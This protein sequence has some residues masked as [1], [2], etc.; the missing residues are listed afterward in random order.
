MPDFDKKVSVI[1][2]V[3]NGEKSLKKCLDSVVNQTIDKNLIEVIAVDDGSSDGTAEILNGYEKEYPFFRCFFVE[4]G[5]PAQARNVGIEMAAGKYLA[6]LDSDDSISEDVLRAC[7]EFFDSRYDETDV[8]TY[9]LVPVENG[10]R[11][12]LHYRYDFLRKT[13]VYDLNDSVYRYS[14]LTNINV[15]VKN[16]GDE[17]ILFD[18][19]ND[20]VYEN[21]QYCTDNLLR[22]MT[23]GFVEGCE[24]LYER[25]A[26]SSAISSD[27]AA[28]FEVSFSKWE[29]TFASFDGSAPPYIQALFFD[30]LQL[31]LSEDTL[32][33][34]HFE[35]KPFDDA[36]DRIRQLLKKVSDGIILS[37]TGYPEMLGFY[38]LDM[39]YSGSLTFENGEKAALSYGDEILYETD[40]VRIVIDKF[41]FKG[42]ILEVCGHLSSPVFRYCSKPQLLIRRKDSAESVE[43]YESSFCYEGAK[44]KTNMAWGFRFETHTSADTDFA[45]N[46]SVDGKS[47][48]GEL[49]CGEW[50]P[51][52]KELG[53]S[54]VV[55]GTKDCRF[56]DKRIVIKNTDEKAERTYRVR[57]AFSYL[58][59]N[60]KI[61][62][63][64]FLN[65]F[66]PKKRIWLYHDCASVEKDNGY[67]QFIH[68]FYKDDGVERYYV[69]NGD[70]KSRLELFD[71]KQRKFLIE[72][73][74]TKHKFLY[75]NAEKIITAFIETVNYVPFFSDVYKYYNDLFKAEVV[76]LQHGVLHAHLPWKYSYDRLDLSREVVSTDF[77]VK[78][79]TENYCFPES[80]LIKSKMPRYDFTDCDSQPEENRILF[81]P[82][83]RKY[84]IRLDG[85]GRWSAMYDRFTES[86]YYRKTA[87]FLF[88]SRLA[89]IL[90]ENDWYLDV[91][92]HPIFAVYTDCFNIGNPR[93][94]FT[95]SVSQ[96]DYKV[97]ITDYSSF[98]FDFVYLKRAVVY[99]M[100]DYSRFK[101]GMNDYRQLDIPFEDGFGEF[102]QTAD[103]AVRAVESIIK[104]GGKPIPPFDERNSGFFF[105]CNKDC[106]DKIYEALIQ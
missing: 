27:S 45:F 70:M 63:V 47:L 93:I 50:I 43:L 18:T 79:F 52:K 26:R 17:N 90:E 40:S 49:V 82:S 20:F 38:F 8:V 10:V 1:I 41:R 21:M 53:R 77:E 33:P 99:F 54:R 5:G 28:L 91:K 92:L 58:R 14:A 106:R 24:Y 12:K 29:Q 15:L 7:S 22:K 67:L 80:A 35:G 32:L 19:T 66:F 72:F 97:L 57:E 86:E 56:N 62:L 81:A 6:F 11:K 75:L 55:L 34:Y 98:V 78:N 51:I 73:R 94:R 89:E 46:V 96:N 100:P 76:Y 36:V 69:I 104:N 44:V 61:F 2:P 30:D 3:Y 88:D 4:N 23:V 95:D 105:N 64:R 71:E 39:K 101:A 65:L 74:S 85:E 48:G 42:D 102:T 59:K 60:I 25:N 103:E 13:G 16:R 68:D 84:L 9:S 37:H 83:W 31:K 87:E